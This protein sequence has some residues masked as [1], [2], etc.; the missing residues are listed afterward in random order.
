[1]LWFEVRQCC[2]GKGF[3]GHPYDWQSFKAS[4]L[5]VNSIQKGK[6]EKNMEFLNR[7]GKKFD[8]YN[9]EIDCNDNVK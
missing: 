4:K 5:L 6:Q 1:M 7:H 8:W 2:D 3:Q 9:E